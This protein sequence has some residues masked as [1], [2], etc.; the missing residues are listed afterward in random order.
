MRSA[1]KQQVI[2]LFG[3]QQIC[4]RPSHIAATLFSD[5]KERREFV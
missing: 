3:T 1:D 4:T 2:R 5:G